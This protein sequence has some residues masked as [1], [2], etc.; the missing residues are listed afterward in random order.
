MADITR[1]YH[2]DLQE[3]N[4]SPETEEIRKRTREQVKKEIPQHQKLENP[5]SPLHNLLN[6]QQIYA[7]LYVSK[8]G[9]AAGLDGIP[10]EIWKC[11]DQKHKSDQQEEK[12][13]FNVIKTL[14][15]II[16][17][18]QIHGIDEQTEFSLGWMC[19]IYKKKD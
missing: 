12:P 19:P 4:W 14:T 18:I 8:A 17:D 1:K 7:A 6:K 9:S 3:N 10:Y 2:E 15:T 5:H 13:S 11:L 16:N